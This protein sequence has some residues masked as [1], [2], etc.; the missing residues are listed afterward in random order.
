MNKIEKAKLKDQLLRAV[1]VERVYPL[2]E[3]DI[4][5]SIGVTLNELHELKSD[6]LG[7]Y[8]DFIVE[9]QGNGHKTYEV[10]H[11]DTNKVYFFLNNGGFVKQEQDSQVDKDRRTLNDEKLIYEV[12]NIKRI[13]KTYWW[14]FGA[15]V[16]ALLI[17]LW[18]LI[19]NLKK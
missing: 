2:S 18:N 9:R 17:S 13:Y 19:L 11:K 3:F 1:L 14:T 8:P 10:L 15:A 16:A 4:A 12:A 7:Q 5:N 6:I